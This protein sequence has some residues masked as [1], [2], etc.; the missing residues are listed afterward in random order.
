MKHG[1]GFSFAEIREAGLTPQFAQTVGI[2]VD[3]RRHNKNADYQAANVAR[4]NQ[5]KSKLLLFPRHAGVAKKGIIADS[6]AEKLKG[7]KE[8]D[9]N[10]TKGVFDVAAPKK[11]CKTAALTKDVLGFR[12]YHNLR[13]AR[14]NK[15]YQGIRAKRAKEAEEKKK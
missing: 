2:A 8:D 11:R 15:R 3:H 12:A 9:Q 10:T 6:T 4:L 1:R 13:L 7:I 14:T 5:Y